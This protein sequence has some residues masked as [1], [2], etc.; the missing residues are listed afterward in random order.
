MGLVSVFDVAKPGEKILFA[1]YGSGAGSDAIIF[2]IT[3][4]I[5]EKRKNFLKMISEKTYIHYITYS[6]NMGIIK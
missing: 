1:S 2:N 6:R 5:V 3:D 4:K